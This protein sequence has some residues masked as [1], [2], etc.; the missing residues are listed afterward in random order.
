MDHEARHVAVEGGMVVGA[1]LTQ[2]HK[3][4]AGAWRLVD[5]QLEYQRAKVGLQTH[6]GILGLARRQRLEHGGFLVDG[7]LF[8]ACPRRQTRRRKARGCAAG[9]SARRTGRL[10]LS[11]CVA[12]LFFGLPVLTKLRQQGLCAARRSGIHVL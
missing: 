9:R 4:V 10:R 11:R 7:D 5:E 6:D 8:R 3:I 2:C 12:C 1:A